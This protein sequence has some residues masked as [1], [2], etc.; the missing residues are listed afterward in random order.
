MA[1][2]SIYQPSI[3]VPVVAAPQMRPNQTGLVIA[4]AAERVYNAYDTKQREDAQVA[5]STERIKADHKFTTKFLLDKN[6]GL[7]DDAYPQGTID[8]V[9]EHF[10]DLRTQYAG[11]SY[12][13][14]QVDILE[15]EIGS[16][17]VERAIVGAAEAKRTRRMM[18][19]SEAA[20]TSAALLARDPSQADSVMAT[21]ESAVAALKHPED[22]ARGRAIA[23]NVAPSIFAGWLADDNGG[24]Q[25]ALAE[26]NSGRWDNRLDGQTVATIRNQAK[27]RIT[28]LSQRTALN[29]QLDLE[30]NVTKGTKQ[31]PAPPTVGDPEVQ[32]KMAIQAENYKQ[33]ALKTTPQE[34]AAARAYE[35]T[36]SGGF[37]D[38]TSPL[39][40]RA[41]NVK[42]SGYNVIDTSTNQPVAVPGSRDIVN[43]A[44]RDRI[45]E[46]A[47]GDPGLKARL[48][49]PSPTGNVMDM[50]DPDQRREV[51][52][53]WTG[54]IAL[55]VGKDAIIPDE[56]KGLVHGPLAAHSRATPQQQ[57]DAAALY[58][59]LQ[60]EGG[61]ALVKQLDPTL[62]ARAG[63][64]RRELSA[65]ASDEEAVNAADE[66][67]KLNYNM[68]KEE[69]ATVDAQYAR[70]K[71]SITPGEQDLN[72]QYISKAM[73]Q[74]GFLWDT[75]PVV[76]ANIIAK[77]EAETLKEYRKTNDLAIA[78]QTA[79]L[80]VR[81][82]YQ[83]TRVNGAPVV[84]KYA[85]EAYYGVPGLDAEKQ[86][87]WIRKQAEDDAAA[88]DV[89][90]R[91]AFTGR[92]MVHPTGDLNPR[93]GLPT[94]Y[95]TYREKKADGTLGA[96]TPLNNGKPWAPDPAKQVKILQDETRKKALE[97]RS[98]NSDFKMPNEITPETF[99][100]KK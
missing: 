65:G 8:G 90:G 89:R 2:I 71:K 57:A 93:T 99:G 7:I 68:T 83:T 32:T 91:A 50:L 15:A 100:R 17:S 5:L 69:Q 30:T 14:K 23:R 29:Y 58:G 6:D 78:Q 76:T 25:R 47:N 13:L 66:R 88:G 39:D 45:V 3:T 97:M 31:V 60:R 98:K 38:P 35:V 59:K 24:P 67:E 80:K 11:N 52:E 51:R 56:V 36:M 16:Q 37:L 79:E 18:S 95:L 62:S 64:I 73:S 86:A 1:K 33:L 70:A 82:F 77:F 53:D 84:R 55:Q 21:L 44:V 92:V 34:E 46:M 48:S 20:E 61:E 49:K 27:N 9:K 26:L 43:G 75:N 72:V 87:E 54:M 28:E 22:V 4:D 10:A 81:Q 94:Y 12:F 85:P 74:P 96:E 41:A 63:I 19:I 42:W 40:K